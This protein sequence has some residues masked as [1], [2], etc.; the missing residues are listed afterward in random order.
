[1]G[2]ERL[3]AEKLGISWCFMGKRGLDGEE[4][5]WKGRLESSSLIGIQLTWWIDRARMCVCLLYAP[6][7]TTPEMA[8]ASQI[9]LNASYLDKK[10]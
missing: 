7:P 1:M 6:L 2:S 9:C 3:L 8:Q 5:E 10:H 4:V